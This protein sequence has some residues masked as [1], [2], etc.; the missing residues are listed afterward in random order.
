MPTHAQAPPAA[1]AAAAPPSACHDFARAWKTVAREASRMSSQPRRPGIGIAAA[2]SRPARAAASRIRPVQDSYGLALLLILVTICC[3][4]VAGQDAVARLI[5]VVLGGVTLLFVLRAS[6]ASRRVQRISLL[7]VSGAVLSASL[8]IIVGEGDWPTIGAGLVSLLLAFVAPLLILRHIIRSLRVSFQLVLGALCVYLLLGLVYTY[9]F[10]IIATVGDA[11][12]F[13]QLAHPSLPDF[14][15]F[16][17]TTLSTTGYGDLTAAGSLERMIGISEALMGQLFLVSA[18]A[19]LAGNIGRE[20]NVRV[21]RRGGLVD[22]ETNASADTL[23]D[24]A[25]DGPRP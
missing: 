22:R 12:F 16:S 6:S 11:Q 8:V 17:Y 24:V 18:V 1:P 15:Y 21:D 2:Q 14:L 3:L 13:V 25:A 7:V 20:L 23:D 9:L 5:S 4:A 19:V 10:A